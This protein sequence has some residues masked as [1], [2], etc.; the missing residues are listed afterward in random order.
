MKKLLAIS[1]ILSLLLCALPA[2]AE[3]ALEAA[4]QSV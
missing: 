1:L 3:G 4:A 2:P